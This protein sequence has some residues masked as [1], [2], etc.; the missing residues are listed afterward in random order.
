MTNCA[1]KVHSTANELR[2]WWNLFTVS[3]PDADK[4]L[5]KTEK[6]NNLVIEW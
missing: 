6:V 2:N 1:R 5:Q 4:G 3:P